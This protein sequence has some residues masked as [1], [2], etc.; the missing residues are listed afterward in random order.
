MKQKGECFRMSETMSGRQGNGRGQCITKYGRL[1]GR[2]T[3]LVSRWRE[4]AR[5]WRRSDER[6]VDSSDARRSSLVAGGT[7][8]WLDVVRH[9]DSSSDSGSSRVSSS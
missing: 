5:A 7:A 1:R 6:D 9:G 2:L 4:A 3:A 8:R